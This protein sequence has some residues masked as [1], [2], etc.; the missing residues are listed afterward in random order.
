MGLLTVKE[1]ATRLGVTPRRVHHLATRG[2][3]RQVARGVIDAA[4]VDR[5]QAVRGGTHTQAWAAATAWGAVGL[6]S[7]VE[8]SWMGATQRSRLKKRLADLE[9]QS[10]VERTRNR[11]AVTRYRAHTGSMSHFLGELVRSPDPTAQLGLTGVGHVDGYL[12]A[13]RLAATVARHG[14]IRD[15]AGRVTL[16]S[17][18]FD[19]R[20]VRVLMEGS[21]VLAGLDAAESLEVRE[22]RAGIAV[23]TEALERLRE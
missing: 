18:D 2:E 4:S 21:V 8:V 17:T 12:A 11:A 19:L 23:L 13:D 20:V 5:F 15:D 7:G 9:P 22:R 10:L 6:L 3:L 1:V 16:R 14:L